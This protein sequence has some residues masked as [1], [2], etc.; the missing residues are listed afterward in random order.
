M[1]EDSTMFLVLCVL[2]GVNIILSLNYTLKSYK[3]KETKQKENYCGC[4]SKS[5]TLEMQMPVSTGS[6]TLQDVAGV[7]GVWK[8]QVG[9]TLIF[10]QDGTVNNNSMGN[11]TFRYNSGEIYPGNINFVL[12]GNV[13]YVNDPDRGSVPYMPQMTGVSEIGA[14]GVWKNQVGN[15]LTFNQDGTGNNNSMGNFTFKYNT[16]AIYPGNI[17]FSMSGNVLYVNDPDRG[18]VTYMRQ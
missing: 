8:N 17:N 1:E 6:P 4:N 9:N 12:S 5:S 11:F 10:N 3:E 16:G 18:P 2:L 14:T 7:L 15:I 13:L